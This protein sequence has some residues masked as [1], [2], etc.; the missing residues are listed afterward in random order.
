[1]DP[2]S[3]AATVSQDDSIERRSGITASDNFQSRTLDSQEETKTF[4]HGKLGSLP[5]VISSLRGSRSNSA[6]D[7]RR[8]LGR[9]RE[10]T[11]ARSCIPA[12]RLDDGTEQEFPRGRDARVVGGKPLVSVDISSVT[13]ESYAKEQ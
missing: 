1:M 2:T 4:E 8:M 12:T 5:S 13:S 9:K 6:G 10:P 11:V 7:G 3:L